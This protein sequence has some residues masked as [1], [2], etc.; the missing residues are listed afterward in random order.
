MTGVWPGE[1]AAL[2]SRDSGSRLTTLLVLHELVVVST[3]PTVRTPVP[4]IA[5]AGVATRLLP[6]P[7]LSIAGPP[8]P[9]MRLPS[10][11][12]LAPPM[13]RGD[14]HHRAIVEVRQGDSRESLT[15]LALD[16][17]ERSLLLAG[18]QNEGIPRCAGAARSP[19][20]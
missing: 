2:A 4:V 16:A 19:D 9:T 20:A 13:R 10:W 3:L 5:G 15:H 7:S 14:G 1:A 6:S 11:S 12:L 17:G 8:H 18:H